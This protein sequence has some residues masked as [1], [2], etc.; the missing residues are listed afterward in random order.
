MIDTNNDKYDNKNIDD[1]N[2]ND[3]VIKLDELTPINDPN[4]KHYFVKDKDSFA[5]EVD[6]QAWICRECRRGAILPKNQVIINS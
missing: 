6:M 1:K 4:C 3:V 2:E 5:E